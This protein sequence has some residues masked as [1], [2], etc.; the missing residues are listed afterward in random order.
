M[1]GGVSRSGPLPDGTVD[2]AV[3]GGGVV[4]AAVARELAG[5][6]ADGRALSVALVE[7]RSDVGDGTS[8]ANTAILHTGFD[9]TPG[10]LESR[11]V[12]RGYELLGGY[13]ERAGIPVERTGAV[14][15]AW[16]GE[17]LA[18]LPALADKA[19]KNGYRQCEIVGADEVYGLVPALGPGALGG[20]TVPG[21][22]IICPWTTTLA[23]ATEALAR[24]AGVLLNT[25]VEGV[26]RDGGAETVLLTNRGPLRARWVVNAAGLGSD[27][28]D[29]LFGHERFTVTPR[30]GELLVF[31]KMARPLANRIVLPVPSS[32]GKG[33]LISPTIYGN[34]MLGPTAEDLRD[35]ADTS[36]SEEGFAFLVDKGL[37]LMPELLKEEVT[38]S[39][40]GLRAATERGDYQ[41]HLDAA[42]RYLVLGGIRSTG[43]TS[44]M[45]LAEHAA[46]LLADAGLVTSV[47]DELPEPPRMPNIGEAFPRPYMCDDLIAQDPAYGTVVCF[48]ERVTAGEIRDALASPL[49]PADID[50][51]RRRTRAMMGRCQGFFCGAEVGRRLAPVPDSVEESR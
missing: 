23:F 6:E 38:A 26:Q 43:L 25:R 36:T 12:R 1:N 45:A 42:E 24:G 21:E 31:D 35:R 33:V 11:L 9:A 15:V 40:A 32:R 47:R 8:K 10:T 27:A 28:V 13:A 14:L 3:V 48:C 34:V 16:T 30:R 29:R 20:L 46:G 19:V 17:E 39:Y 51:L 18:A 5:R 4:G 22:S 2:V 50:G 44:S 49:P 37:A 41:V 7:A